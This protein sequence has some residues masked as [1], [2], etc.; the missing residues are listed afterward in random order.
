MQEEYTEQDAIQAV[1]DIAKQGLENE[2]I[3]NEIESD[4]TDI[5]EHIINIDEYLVI[6]NKE[7]EKKDEQEAEKVDEKENQKSGEGEQEEIQAVTLDD[8]YNEVAEV[9]DNLENTNN[10]LTVGVWT[11]GIVIG[12]LLLTIFWRKFFK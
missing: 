11:Q 3:L 5:N 7:E 10:L 4:L 9:N 1:Q 8:I 12:V 6:N 2:E